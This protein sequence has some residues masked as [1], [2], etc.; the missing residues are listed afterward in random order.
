M[1]L[2]LAFTTHNEP[3]SSYAIAMVC[4]GNICRSPVAEVVLSAKLAAIGLSDVSVDSAGTGSWHV[5]EPID[6]R[7]AAMLVDHGYD[8]RPHRARQ[9]SADWFDS[10]DLVLAMDRSNLTELERIS[11]SADDLGKIS[12]F[13]SFDPDATGSL[14]VPDPW[15]GGRADFEN[16][17]TV[18]ER[19]TDALVDELRTLS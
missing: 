12:M 3:D 4:L 1:T 9:F 6:P 19:T 18:V 13:R 8:P 14:D 7:A 10:H 17:L 16:V 11:R 15:Y 5:G 2:P